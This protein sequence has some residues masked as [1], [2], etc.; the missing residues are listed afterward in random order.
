LRKG[1]IAPW[2]RSTSP[3]YMQTLEALAKAY[4]F[5][6]DA[7]WKELP[8]KVQEMILY[9]SG[10]DVIRF[11][12]D[13]GTRSYQTQKPFEGVVTSLERRDRETESEW[14]R[15]D[16]VK[17]FTDVPC[18]ACHGFR[19]KPEALAVKVAGLH[20]GETAAMSVKN[21]VAWSSGLPGKLTG[22]Q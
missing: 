5:S 6:L 14:A 20:I 7:K 15:A 22:K 1:A 4:K 16:L 19:L 10:D 8:K 13:D 3:Y 2:A 18:S 9:G 12:Y 11:V 17:S 21:A